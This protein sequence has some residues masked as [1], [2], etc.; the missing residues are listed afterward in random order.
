MR[1]RIGPKSL[2]LLHFAIYYRKCSMYLGTYN[3][4][5]KDDKIKKMGVE[6]HVNKKL[7]CHSST[8]ILK[9]SLW[10]ESRNRSCRA[11]PTSTE[12]LCGGKHTHKMECPRFKS[13]TKLLILASF[14]WSFLTWAMTER[15]VL[16]QLIFSISPNRPS[17]LFWRS[18]LRRHRS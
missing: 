6:L 14:L 1:Y 7:G 12:E 11:V 17:C 16:S 15:N 3:V 8:Y 5:E 18:N 2:G 13:Q 4:I 10:G 9:H